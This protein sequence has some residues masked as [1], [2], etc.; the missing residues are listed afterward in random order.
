MTLD[1]FAF[2]F[3]G[4][5][6][7]PALH[8]RTIHYDGFEAILIGMDRTDQAPALAR[9]VAAAGAQLIELCG[10]FDPEATARVI[11]AIDNEVPVGVVTY[12]PQAILG[13]ARL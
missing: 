4:R 8:R 2:L 3:V 12:G 11:A 5:G 6:L 10:A 9:E 13:M 7:D 1:K